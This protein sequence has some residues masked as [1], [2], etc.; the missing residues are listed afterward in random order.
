MYKTLEEFKDAYIRVL[1]IIN[2]QNAY[3][4]KLNIKI[5]ELEKQ[6]ETM[7]FQGMS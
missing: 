2:T 3:I 6:I 4:N 7:K 5:I 1:K